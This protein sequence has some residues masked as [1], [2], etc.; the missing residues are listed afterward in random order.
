MAKIDRQ[1]YA[2]MYGPTVGDKIRLADT[3][4]FAEIER[5]FTVY[6]EENKFGGGKT[7]RDGMAQSATHLRDE[8]VL[9]MVITN[10]TIIDY[11]GIVKADIGI[12]D[13]K[14]SSCYNLL[15]G[16]A[17][18]DRTCHYSVTIIKHFKRERSFPE[19]SVPRKILRK[20]HLT[21]HSSIV[22]TFE[23]VRKL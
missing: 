2:S 16:S 3:E 17:V 4:L 1:K 7:L 19:I 22:R 20:R 12:K 14:I 8:G 13:G 11:W 5:D 10:A 23:F 21:E 18:I 6:G 9:D 15:S